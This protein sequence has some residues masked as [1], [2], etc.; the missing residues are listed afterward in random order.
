MFC[1]FR[2]VYLLYDFFSTFHKLKK[3]DDSPPVIPPTVTKPLENSIDRLDIYVTV[4]DVEINFKEPHP[5][6]SALTASLENFMKRIA[7]IGKNIVYLVSFNNLYKY[8]RLYCVKKIKNENNDTEYIN[9]PF[10]PGFVSLL[11]TNEFTLPYND[12]LDR[13]NFTFKISE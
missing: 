5:K 11:T 8:G 1:C 6:T 7:P 13:A 10:P 9:V 3:T 4:D 2:R 12:A